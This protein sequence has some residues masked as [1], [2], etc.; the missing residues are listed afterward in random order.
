MT[1]CSHRSA[2]RQ[3]ARAWAVSSV[4][5]LTVVF[6]SEFRFTW[7]KQANNASWKYV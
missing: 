2:A 1:C 7:C 6:R 5:D 4:L 3:R